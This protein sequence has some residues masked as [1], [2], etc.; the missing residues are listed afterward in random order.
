MVELILM[1]HGKA[2]EANSCTTDYEREL[3]S[4]GRRK[5]ALAVQGIQRLLGQRSHLYI[6]SSP[7]LRAR[8]TAD[9]L[10]V[11]LGG[12]PVMECNAIHTGELEVLAC[13]WVKLPATA[14]LIIIGHQ[15]ILSHWGAKIADVILPFKKAAAAGFTLHD[16]HRI[17]GE[18]LWFAQPKVLIDLAGIT[19]VEDR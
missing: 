7:L 11:A 15:P 17:Q 19:E 3:T 9:L 6:W 12:L 16:P 18:L 1:R 5:T 8:Q 2:E 4:K 10:A 14:T 13:E